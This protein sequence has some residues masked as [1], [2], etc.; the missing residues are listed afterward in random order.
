MADIPINAVTRRVQYTSVGS[1]GPYSFS[2]A[3]L[4]EGDLAVYD[5]STLKTRTTHYTVSLNADGTGLITFTGG[6]EP[7]SGNIVTIESNQAIERTTDY[8]T[9]GDFT[10]A[11][12]NTELDQITI[13]LQQLE[14]LSRKYVQL[15]S[16]ANRDVSSGGLGPLKF[17]YDDT[18]ANQADKAIVFDSNGTA[19]T[20]SSVITPASLTGEALS[21]LR[22]NAG[23]TA[24]EFRTPSEVLSDISGI[25]ASSSDT[26][27]NKSIALGSNTITGT[28]AQFNTAL[29]DGSFVTL[30]G[31]ETL[32]NKTLTLPTLTAPVLNGTL[33]GTGI[34]DEDNMAS[35]SATGVPTQQSVKAYVDALV[36]SNGGNWKASVK[37]ATTANITLSGEQ[38]I[39]GVLTSASRILVKDQTAPA[40][41]GVY[42]TDAG[43]WSRAADADTWDELVSAAIFVEE[44]TTNQDTSYICTVDDGGTLDTT[45]VVWTQFGVGGGGG[46][47]RGNNGTVGSAPGD[48]FRVNSATLTA[49]EEIETGENASC[50]GPL[51]VD[52]GVTLTVTGTLVII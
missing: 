40:E 15:D 46:L 49:D 30:A 11:S 45:S 29:S 52:S 38:T 28:T 7:T 1:A 20:T 50:T 19:L 17:P 6:N 32:T 34:L 43:A 27:T 36:S 4:D 13:S 33:S 47:F 39:D 24:Y 5:A 42:V 23:E 37:V 41:N 25:S 16:F 3:I 8:S 31:T 51:S 48:I 10:A 44:G 2:F 21:M 22:V 18:P 12:I 35:N 14:T 9:S 26:L